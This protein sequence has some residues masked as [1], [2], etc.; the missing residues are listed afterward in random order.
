LLEEVNKIELIKK[1]DE[2]DPDG[3]DIISND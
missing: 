1:L 2:L 3:K